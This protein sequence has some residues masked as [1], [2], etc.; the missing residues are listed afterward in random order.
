MTALLSHLIKFLSTPHP[1]IFNRSSVLLP[2]LGTFAVILLLKPFE[3]SYLSFGQLLALAFFF[4]LVV[5]LCVWLVV[6]GFLFL[7]F[8]QEDNWTI[9][10]EATL[11]FGV[12]A[13][14]S[15]LIFALFLFWGNENNAW[16]LFQKVVL[17]TVSISVFPII[18]FI[19][20]EQLV[21]QKKQ[22]KIALQWNLHLQ[23]KNWYHEDTNSAN[24]VEILA[25]N[26]KLALKIS[27]AQI[28][29]I[30]A[31]GNY[32][33]V[34]YRN[35]DILEKELVRNRLKNIQEQLKSSNFLRC[36][37]SFVVNM[38]ELLKVE[39][40]ARNFTLK[41]KDIEMSIPV[42]RAMVKNISAWVKA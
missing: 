22:A 23:R 24:D 33:E 15:F 29:Y 41:L 8:I 28:V 14:I 40:N 1:F 18:L 16:K 35:Q 17:K 4:G 42:S 36:H 30:Q 13:S 32:T 21:H 34:Y 3:F 12:L 11:V 27:K 19:L 37:R 2:F 31:E 6:K 5:S 25:E 7:F 39:G 26:G 10:K 20:F 9:G 38:N